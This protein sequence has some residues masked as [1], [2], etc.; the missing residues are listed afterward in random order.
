L[1]FLCLVAFLLNPPNF[2]PFL[3]IFPVAWFRLLPQSP[4]PDVCCFFP[5]RLIYGP[6]PDP[7]KGRTPRILP[8]CLFFPTKGLLG[9]VQQISRPSPPL[10]LSGALEIPF[11]PRFLLEL[12]L[13]FDVPPPMT[14]LR[15]F[16]NPGPC[17]KFPFQPP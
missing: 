2:L 14:K 4:C 15:F 10:L 1:F 7:P 16:P 5:L 6:P 17:G 3:C 8:F 12:P 13:I 11:K 9:S